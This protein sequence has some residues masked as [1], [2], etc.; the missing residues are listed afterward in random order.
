MPCRSCVFWE[1]DH[2]AG[3]R[4]VKAGDPELEKEAWISATLLQ[5]GS[6]GTVAYVDNAPVGY[7]LY[8]PPAFV[9]RSAMFPTSPISA[10][11]LQLITARVIPELRGTGIG[12]TL[13]QAAAHNLM[14]RGI[15]AVETFGDAKK[16]ESSC[17]LPADFLLAV[18]FKTVRAHH[19]WPRLRLDLRTSLTLSAEVEVAIDR[20]IGVVTPDPALRPV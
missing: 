18:G 10:D 20:L 8:A 4:A 6:C 14:R 3:E 2:V 7:V 1:L 17:L 16:P 12:R 13:V 19:H 15:R 11:A 5:W 9:P